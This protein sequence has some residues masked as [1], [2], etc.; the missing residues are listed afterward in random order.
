MELG[1]TIQ[2][3]PNIENPRLEATSS[4]RPVRALL[5]L[6]EPALVRDDA[7]DDVA[8]PLLLALLGFLRH[9]VVEQRDEEV[10]LQDVGEHDPGGPQHREQEG[11]SVSA[12]GG[13]SLAARQLEDVAEPITQRRG[14]HFVGGVA[15]SHD[16][17]LALLSVDR[18]RRDSALPSRI[19][20]SVVDRV[21]RDSSQ[22]IVLCA[23]DCLDRDKERQKKRH[24]HDDE[25]QEIL[26]H[27]LVDD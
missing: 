5:K 12:T 2:N 20:R 6:R 10:E 22:E 7:R 9:G 13:I 17:T 23:L 14:E 24:V 21:V 15:G 25:I 8:V 18:K 1:H 3:E 16:A 27:H 19:R 26:C 11:G 4:R